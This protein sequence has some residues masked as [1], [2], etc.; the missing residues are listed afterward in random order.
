MVS[1]S[2]APSL[3]I[4][5]SVSDFTVNSVSNIKIYERNQIQK[6][7]VR[8]MRKLL[9]QSSLKT[10]PF[11]VTIMV[12]TGEITIYKKSTTTHRVYLFY[13]VSVIFVLENKLRM[14]LQTIE[15]KK[16][17]SCELVG[18]L[19]FSVSVIFKWKINLHMCR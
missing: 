13:Y 12:D 3:Q 1:N 9:Q 16:N 15:K 17:W 19:F 8:F 5:S 6:L 14:L 4:N 11:K 2:A 10:I 7:F 18:F